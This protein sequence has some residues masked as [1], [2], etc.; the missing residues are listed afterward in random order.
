MNARTLE[1]F[2]SQDWNILPAAVEPM[3]LKLASAENTE[4][5]MKMP[6]RPDHDAGGNELPKLEITPDGIAIVPI[7]G[8]LVHNATGEDKYWYNVIAHGDVA[9]DL[10]QALAEGARAVLLDIDSPGGTVQGT[11]ELAGKIDEVAGAVDVFSFNNGLCC[12]AAEYLSVGA[13]MRMGLPSSLNGSIGVI[14]Q[15]F[16]FSKMLE[17]FGVTVNLFT[18]G[19]F[20]GTGHPAK[21][22]T[23]DQREYLQAHVKMMADEFKGHVRAH[24]PSMTDELMQGQTFTGKQALNI[25]LLDQLVQRRSQALGLI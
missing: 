12:S 17:R 24:R 4:R 21:A 23:D 19:K 8:P 3:L 5:E 16:D 1:R 9:D 11:E 2:F 7:K 15:T 13:V 20:K 18:S 14:L 22:L 10:D 6:A 25:E